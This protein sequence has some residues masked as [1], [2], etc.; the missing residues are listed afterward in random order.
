MKLLRFFLPRIEYILFIAIFWGIVAN[1]PRILNFDGDLPRHILTG[2]LILQTHRVPTT[3]IFSFRTTGYPSFPHEW[4]SQVIF[5]TAYDWLGLDGVVLLA[6]L[7]IMLTWGI[8]YYETIRKS[9][10][11]FLALVFIALGVGAS[12]IHVLPRPHILT[13][14]LTAIW[15]A[16]LES[17][18][19]NKIRSWW[20]LPFVMLLWVNL[21]GMFVLGIAILGI[22]LVGDFLDQPSMSWFRT[23]IARSLL[24]AGTLS[25]MATFFSPSGPKIWEAIASLG[26]N[27]YIT[28][29]IPEYQSPNF[30][31]PETWPFVMILLLTIA[32][33]ARR[34]ERLSWKQILLVISFTGVA[35]Y[36]GRMIPL[37]AIVVTP[38]G[39]KTVADWLRKDYSQSRF[40]T[41][42]ENIYKINSTS[43]GLVWILAIVLFAAVLLKSGRTLDPQGQGNVF[44]ER[45]FPVEAVSWLKTHPQNGHMFN[46]FDWGGYLL[47]NLWPNQQI[48][49]DGH[50]HIYGE[51]LTREYEQVITQGNGWEEI[52]NKYDVNWVIIRFN[53]SLAKALSSSADWATAYADR[54]AIIFVHK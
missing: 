5:A 32:G 9:K 27:S 37:F 15:I 34:T 11:F 41:I 43:N 25:V 49:M 23:N 38:I 1:G 17:I 29:K 14:L 6:A 33:L 30:H 53:T 44:D 46:E 8:V 50:T 31:L 24:L 42:E 48:F 39:A 10:S 20:L 18:E 52:L 35:L 36:T 54:T 3:D 22:Y 28:S 19:D 12:Q 40:F 51:K 45:F 7:V 4:L 26:S 47:L 16:L 2:N 13:Y 21:H